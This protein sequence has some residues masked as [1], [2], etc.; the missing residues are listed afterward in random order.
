[1]GKRPKPQRINLL[2]LFNLNDF[3]GGWV[4]GDFSPTIIKTNKF[5]VSVKSYMKGDYQEE[6]FHKKAEEVSIIIKGSARMNGKIYKKDDIVLIEK[7]ESTDF[8]PLEDE[9]ITCVI[10]SPSVVGD[11]YFTNDTNLSQR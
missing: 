2:K 8:M 3:K 6:H 10:K 5:E 4:A 7:G 11:K 9:T 1:M